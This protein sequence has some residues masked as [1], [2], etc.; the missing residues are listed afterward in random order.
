[1]VDK[2]REMQ[3]WERVQVEVGWLAVA[4]SHSYSVDVFTR[5]SQK[6]FENFL[7]CLKLFRDEM[8]KSLEAI[9]PQ[10]P[11]LLTQSGGNISSST[12]A[13]RSLEQ[14]W[15]LSDV[16]TF[17]PSG[18][19]E[20]Y[21]PAQG[22]LSPDPSLPPRR[23]AE[24]APAKDVTNVNKLSVNRE[25]PIWK[26]EDNSCSLDVTALIPLLYFIENPT[27]A[28]KATGNQRLPQEF[29]T[30]IG[31]SSGYGSTWEQWNWQ[32]LT[33]LRDLIREH[34]IW[35]PHSGLDTEG[36]L[37]DGTKQ[38]ISVNSSVDSLIQ[39]FAP[40]EFTSIR[41]VTTFK[42]TKL[43]CVAKSVKA[44]DEA[45]DEPD[46]YY[47]N[48]PSKNIMSDGI[49]FDGA[50]QKDTNTRD[51]MDLLVFPNPYTLSLI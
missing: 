11:R 8:I 16:S 23:K 10:F 43:G 51:L 32:E 31:A 24:P 3:R 1:M 28:I 39:R 42:C 5:G 25:L 15:D 14:G 30:V 21:Q 29:R 46:G 44:G 4:F 19:A 37:R 12:S 13:D 35:P 9:W 6:K 18:Q 40:P 2:R 27:A 50:L 36:N 38:I 49:T 7:D 20:A 17:R 47:F 22:S 26:W 34:L 41:T 45:G 48:V 33:K